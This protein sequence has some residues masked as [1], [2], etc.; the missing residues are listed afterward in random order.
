[1][2]KETK[3]LKGMTWGHSRGILPLQ[4][5]SQRIKELYPDVEIRWKQ[6]TLQEFAD[7]PIEKLTEHYDL[8][9]IDHPWVGC[10]ADIKCVLPLDQYLS[11]DFM[12]NQQ[13]H[14]V[15]GSH[16]SYNYSGHQWALAIDAATPVASYRADLFKKHDQSLPTTWKEVLQLAKK[17]TVA[18]PAIP[19][20][21]LMN[22]YMFSQMHGEKPFAGSDKVVSDDIGQL[23]LETMKEFYSQLDKELFTANPIKVAELM[24]ST[25]R[26]WYCPFAYG[27]SNYSRAG[28]AQYPLRYT[29]IVK[30][31]EV[32]MRS[33]LGG[34]GLAISSFSSYKEQAVR[35]AEL[36]AS[37]NY[38]RT[39]Y[40]MHG[41]QPG[42]RKAWIDPRNN[43]LT[44]NFFQNTIAT[45]DNAYLRPR[46]HGYLDFQDQAGDYVQNYLMGKLSKLS[47]LEKINTSYRNSKQLIHGN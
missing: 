5:C 46:Y 28:Y 12:Q 17:G 4:A 41:G 7:Y 13:D 10:A 8:L 32:P 18:A 44:D 38:Q 2:S 36:L 1:M 43:K 39:E 14:Q 40:V 24:S 21:L 26:F 20:D 9:I 19:I 22:F 35:F 23:A 27:Y 3:I 45:L 47:A 11:E 29:N 42:H 37:E 25:N 15:G 33:T 6:R 16:D 34:T 31:N 30:Y